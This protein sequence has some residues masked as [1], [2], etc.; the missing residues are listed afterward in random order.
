MVGQFYSYSFPVPCSTPLFTARRIPPAGDYGSFFY[1]GFGSASIPMIIDQF[2]TIVRAFL[3]CKLSF[4][5]YGYGDPFY[6]L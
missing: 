3:F 2:S 1:L 4:V 5:N 6:E